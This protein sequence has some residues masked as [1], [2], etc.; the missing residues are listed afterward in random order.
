MP[1]SH[2][3]LPPSSVSRI[4]RCPPSHLLCASLAD[5]ESSYAKEGT[6][7]HAL[8]EYKLRRALGKRARDPTKN[9]S[10]FDQDMAD[11]TDAYAQFVMEIV[12]ECRKEHADTAVYVEQRVSFSG[13]VPGAYG[14][15][16]AIVLAGHTAY[17]VDLKYGRGVEVS[18]ER[19]EQ[20]MCYALGCIELFDTIY[21]IDEMHL[22]IYQPRLENVSKW[23]TSKAEIQAWARDVLVPAAKLALAGEGEY[24]A[25]DHCV[26]CKAKT[27]CRARAEENMKLARYDFAMPPQLTDTEVEAVLGKV[28]ALIA[29]A[30]GI[31]E[32][33]LH[34]AVQGKKWTDWKLVAGRSSRKYADE[35]AVAEAVK[36]AGYEPYERKLLGITAM[37]SLLGRNKFNELLGKLIVKPKGKPTLVPSSDKRP[38]M[39]TAAEE[40]NNHMEE[41]QNGQENL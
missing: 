4:I 17:V 30:N 6:E 8:A 40:F 7:A 22:I 38:T 21:D 41:N 34:R 24:H 19:N 27:T 33:A 31:K 14:T 37:T 16:D 26:F 35:D 39:T 23:Q 11:N 28:D 32:Y 10:C 5:S 18:A 20:L 29:W 3:P 9:L 1:S 15:A 36:E 25:G 13:F 12:T 2:G